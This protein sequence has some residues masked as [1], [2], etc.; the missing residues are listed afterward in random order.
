M[1]IAQETREEINRLLKIRDEH[2]EVMPEGHYFR[3]MDVPIIRIPEIEEVNLAQEAGLAM[4]P[5]GF[6]SLYKRAIIHGTEY[7][8]QDNIRRKFCNY[9]AFCKTSRLCPNTRF[10]IIERIISFIYE[11]AYETLHMQHVTD[12]PEREFV[13]FQN[14]ISPGFFLPST[15]GTVVV[16]LCNVWE[17][18]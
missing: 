14:I 16:P 9:V 8:I 11:D 10:Y 4:H 6:I 13:R 1:P 3:G 7:R 2:V 5:R 18:D 17:T 15:V 12:V